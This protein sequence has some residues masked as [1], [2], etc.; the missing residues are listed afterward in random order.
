M[1]A[2]YHLRPVLS[3]KWLLR[4]RQSALVATTTKVHSADFADFR[5]PILASEWAGVP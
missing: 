2:A 4:L 1:L 5:E 3:C